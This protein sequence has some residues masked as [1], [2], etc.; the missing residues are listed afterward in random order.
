[1]GIG[2]AQAAVG[3]GQVRSP[4]VLGAAQRLT[5]DRDDIGTVLGSDAAGEEPAEHWVGEKPTV[6]PLD[7]GGN[8]RP[9]ADRLVNIDRRRL[10]RRD[11]IWGNR[12][13]RSPCS[14]VYRDDAPGPNLRD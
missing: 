1:V 5:E 14:G 6:E 11:S 4:V 13:G 10:G 8:S 7:G 9:A 2:D 12:H 3:L